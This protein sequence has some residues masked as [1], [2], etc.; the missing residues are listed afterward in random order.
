MLGEFLTLKS[1]YDARGF[2]KEVIRI[3]E[4]P[5]GFA[6]WSH[7]Y[8]QNGYVMDEFHVHLL[9]TD[10][11]YVPIGKIEVALMLLENT[12]IINKAERFFLGGNTKPRVLRI[13]PG[14]GHQFRVV[15]GP[16]HLFYITTQIY[17]PDDEGR[18]SN[19]NVEFEW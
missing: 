15:D 7:S 11:W 13:L 16:V 12:S 9:Q 10:Y 4:I 8:K 2:F 19:K 5:E 6:Q 18:I 17:N 14:I 3:N 1:Y